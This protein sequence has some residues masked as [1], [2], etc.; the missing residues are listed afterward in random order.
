M[1]DPSNNAFYQDGHN[2]GYEDGYAEGE[3]DGRA[4][5]LT[6]P[7]NVEKAAQ[8]LEGLFAEVDELQLAAIIRSTPRL[9]PY[10]AQGV[11]L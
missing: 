11:L 2:D 3:E 10:L 8:L 9:V 5:A 4:D 7:R 6:L 1:N